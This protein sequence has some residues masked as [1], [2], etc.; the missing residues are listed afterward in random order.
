[1]RQYLSKEKSVAGGLVMPTYNYPMVY[2]G[3]LAD[4]KASL[5]F[6]DRISCRVYDSEGTVTKR[7]R[8]GGIYNLVIKQDVVYDEPRVDMAVYETMDTGSPRFTLSHGTFRKNKV[9]GLYFDNPNLAPNPWAIDIFD[10]EEIWLPSGLRALS[11]HNVPKQFPVTV[12]DNLE[13]CE[14]LILVNGGYAVIKK[15]RGTLDDAS[16]KK[17]ANLHDALSLLTGR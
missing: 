8:N 17:I 15:G 13:Y 9:R 2:I 10:E 3:N 11:L 5:L 6:S 7:C 14:L 4:L 1:M 16:K 12:F